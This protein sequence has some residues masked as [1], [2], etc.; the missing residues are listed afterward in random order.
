MVF[1]K[2][3][4]VDEPPVPV[5]PWADAWEFSITDVERPVTPHRG[6]PVLGI[7]AVRVPRGGGAQRVNAPCAFLPPQAATND[8]CL[9][10]DTETESLLC[11]VDDLEGADGARP[12]RV[13]DRQGQVVGTVR[14]IPPLKHALKPTWRIEQPGHPEIVSSAEWVKGG[15]TEMVQKGTGR[16]L[17][18]ALQAM[19]DMGAEGGDQPAK[20]RT[21]EWRAGG[22]L[23]LTSDADRRF[24]VRAAWLDRRLAF[25]YALLRA[26]P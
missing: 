18:G 26:R 16:F 20:S 23:V 19:A 3:K 4:S 13:R 7:R 15:L 21:L 11:S 10:E 9:Y 24:L 12:Y 6:R 17:L 5:V 25:A 14:R 1:G 8:L 2:S 22:E